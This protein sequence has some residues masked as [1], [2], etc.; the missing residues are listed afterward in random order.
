MFFIRHTFAH[1]K[2]IYEIDIDFYKSNGVKLLLVDKDNTLDS[3]KAYHPSQRAIDLINTLK[4]SGI[5]IAIISNN[6]GQKIVGYAKELGID[7]VTS[8]CKPF[9]RKLN[10]YISKR[11]MPKDNVMFVGDQ[12]VT[13]VGAA[14]KAGIRVVLTDKIVKEDQWTTHIKRIFGRAIRKK[15]Q[16]KGL[17]I[18]WREKYGKD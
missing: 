8:A 17:L 15:H 14:N 12:M 9:A 10:A 6:H 13:D 4:E 18:D 11:N 3:F 7:C 16:R 5:E 2:T 1:A